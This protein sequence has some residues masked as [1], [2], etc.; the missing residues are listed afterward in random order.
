[1]EI[2]QDR[3]QTAFGLIVFGELLP[4]SLRLHSND[5]ICARVVI[6]TAIEYLAPEY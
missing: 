4:Q 6:R 2:D 3:V 1:M 5:G